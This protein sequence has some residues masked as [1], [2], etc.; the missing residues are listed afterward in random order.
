MKQKKR[1][2]GGNNGNSTP[3][4]SKTNKEEEMYFTDFQPQT[5]VQRFAYPLYSLFY[6]YVF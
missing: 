1:F 2:L 4:K 6:F 5:R 3:I